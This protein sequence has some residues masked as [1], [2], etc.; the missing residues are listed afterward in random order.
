MRKVEELKVG[1]QQEQEARMTAAASKKSRGGKDAPDVEEVEALSE[2]EA[3]Q[4]QAVS[5]L[6]EDDSDEDVRAPYNNA[7]GEHAIFGS[8]ENIDVEENNEQ[9]GTTANEQDGTT[10]KDLFGDSSEEESDEELVPSSSK[11]ENEDSADHQPLKK[12]RVLDD[13]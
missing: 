1:W 8:E 5:A 6:F 10:A 11:R 4:G 7:E 13:E 3:K 2:D 12:R 9:D